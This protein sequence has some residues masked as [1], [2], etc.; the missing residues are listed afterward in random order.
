MSY[1]APDCL[2]NA[3]T[4]PHCGVLAK[5]NW[6]GVTWQGQRIQDPTH[7]AC[8]IR[9]GIC[10][11][12]SERTVWHIKTMVYP[13]AGKAPVPNAAMPSRVKELYSEAASIAAKSPRGAAA[14]LRL[15]VQVLC[16]ELG[17]SGKNINDDIKH[18]VRNGLHPLVQKS[19]DTV[20][21]TGNEAVHP[22]QIDTDD[23]EVVGKLFKLVNVIVEYMLELPKHIDELYSDLPAEART[24]IEN[25]DKQG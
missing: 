14:L 2:A 15:A 17:G 3:F 1:V 6:W 4:C 25:R 7:S 16:K 9:V 18:M 12:C 11:S 21:V 10:D 5:Q 8:V 22:G 13:D 23:A 20:R 24:A 19:L